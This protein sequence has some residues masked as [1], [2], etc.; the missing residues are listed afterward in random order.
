MERLEQRFIKQKVAEIA[1]YELEILEREKKC[2][3]F[4]S[5]LSYFK[6]YL[7]QD[8]TPIVEKINRHE[9]P[10]QIIDCL[11]ELKKTLQEQL[12]YCEVVE[13]NIEN[14]FLLNDD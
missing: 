10:V 13:K 2:E 1:T 14:K 7:I 6:K 12:I 11:T 4:L 8:L 3:I 5:Q 9:T